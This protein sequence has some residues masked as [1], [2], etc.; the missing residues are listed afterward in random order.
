MG[1]PQNAGGQDSEL[2]LSDYL[3]ILQR[4]WL[5]VVAFVAVGV[6]AAAVFSAR[7]TPQYRSSVRVLVTADAGSDFFI[8]NSASVQVIERQL[9]NE[10]EFAQSDIVRD[11]ANKAYG[12]PIRVTV[13]PS[14]TADLLTITASDRVA[15]AAAE[16]ANIYARTYVEQKAATAGGSFEEVIRIVDDRLGELG[17]EEQALLDDGQGTSSVR[18]QAIRTEM[19]QLQS[20]KAEF[21]LREDIAASDAQITRLARIASNPYEPNWQ[22]N[23]LLGA[24]AGLVVGL[25]GAFAR[26]GMD[27]RIQSR[28]DL[29]IALPTLPLLGALPPP[30][31]ELGVH[32]AHARSGLYLESARALRS[33]LQFIIADA[34]A[35]SVAITSANAAEGKSTTAVTLAFLAARTGQRV[36][37]IDADLRRPKLAEGLG[38]D[39][40]ESGLREYLSYGDTVVLQEAW[41]AGE[42]PVAFLG[43]GTDGTAVSADLFVAERWPVLI[44]EM[45]EKFDLVI[46]DTSPVLPVTDGVLASAG[47]AM[48]VIVARRD[49]TTSAQLT[50]ALT[51]LERARCVMAGSVLSDA[52][53]ERSYGYSGGYY[54]P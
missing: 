19:A 17:A 46:V 41:V 43:P 36:L 54:R 47:C 26:E 10:I 37:L 34:E 7:T 9:E 35:R 50:T 23:L 40:N 12:A 24:A 21:E 25:A 53:T 52:R 16:K 13:T 44:Q 5:I 28:R 2:R 32:V 33:S 15:E 1:A 45:E 18:I 20:T 8:D 30:E 27:D 31:T 42:E 14:D 4:R 29:E 51:S 39:P 11:E 22:R 48:T 6:V 49:N 38:L 3:A